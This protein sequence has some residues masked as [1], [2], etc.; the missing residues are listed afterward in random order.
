[1]FAIIETGGKQYRVSKGETIQI[2]RL[3]EKDG[4]VVNFDKV[5]LISDGNE[6]KIGKPNLEGA[7]VTGKILSHLRGEK[8]IVFKMKAKKRYKKTIGHRQNHTSIEITDIKSSGAK[9][10]KTEKVDYKEKEAEVKQPEAKEVK[11]TTA[12]KAPAKKTSA[13]KPTKKSESK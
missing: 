9:T 7:C 5:L 1:M 4:S 13:K 6:I 11:K 2:E 10:S 12:K 3:E 8:I